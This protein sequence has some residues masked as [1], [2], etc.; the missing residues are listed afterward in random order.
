MLAYAWMGGMK[1]VAFTDIMQGMALLAG[2]AVLL[3]GGLYLIGG[4]LGSITEYLLAN[5]PEK[6][7]VPPITTGV[8][9]VV[10]SST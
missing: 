9:F 2:V 3:I 5:E 7:A 6:V 1:A 4:N 8:V 10:G